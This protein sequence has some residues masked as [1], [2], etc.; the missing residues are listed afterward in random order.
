MLQKDSTYSLWVCAARQS[1][2]ELSIAEHRSMQIKAN[3]LDTLT[4]RLVDGHSKCEMNR[5][6]S[7][8]ERNRIIFRSGIKGHVRD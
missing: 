6:L 5:E 2:I 8:P 3:S 4:L 7:T 1:H